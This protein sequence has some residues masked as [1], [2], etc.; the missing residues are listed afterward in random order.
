MA[1]PVIVAAVETSELNQTPEV[2]TARLLRWQADACRDLGSPLYGDL[3]TRAADDLVAGGPTAEVL[4]GHFDDRL[5]SVLALRLLGGV[6]ALA[7]S[8]QAPELAVF[9]PSCGG[10][11]ESEP[12]SPRAWA[13]LRRTLAADGESIRSWL[14][15][16]PQTNEVGRAAAL[17]GGL[18]HMAA[19]VSLPIRLVEVG[20]SA[21]LNLRADHFYVPGPA[22]SYGRADSPVVLTDGWLGDPPPAARIEVV[23]R[24][25]GDL[26]P[27]DPL[28]PQGRLRLTAY[29]WPDQT[30]RLGR[31]RGAFEVAEHV[32]AELRTESA[33]VTLAH[34]KV[35]AGTWTVLWHSIF[36]Q[37]LTELQ[38]AELADG[39]SALGATATDSARFAY[40]YLEQSRAGGC[41]VTLTTWPGGQRRILGSAP[42]HGLPVRWH[43]RF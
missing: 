31:L 14:D 6:H 2:R 16:P 4:R 28:T 35:A 8:G 5:P 7:L 32:P 39:I 29:V 3:L 38:R 25:G 11:A 37:Y 13:A 22:G 19:E 15:H 30:G 17:L 42:A 24:T 1:P 9:Y 43:P 40:L 34:T 36:R 27:V 23:E 10:R 41:P 18:R 33:S 26:A 20:A 21:G 12:G